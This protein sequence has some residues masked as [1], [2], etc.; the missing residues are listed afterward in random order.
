M[1]YWVL[2]WI[3]IGPWLRVL[4]RP[5][6]EG[7]EHVPATGPAIL[8]SNHV[9]FIDSVFLPLMV[10]R[11]IRF[12]AKSEYFT[13][14]GLKGWLSRLFF[15]TIGCVPVDRA[16]GRAA[17]AALDAGKQVLEEGKLWGMYPEG[18]RS[19]DGQ[20]YRGKTGVA[21]LA[22]ESG[23]PVI[24]CAMVN[25]HEIQPAGAKLPRLNKRVHMRIGAPLDF[26]R[27]AGMAGD[28]FVERS[29]TDEIMYNLME[30]SGQEYVD[31]YAAKVKKPDKPAHGEA[32]ADKPTPAHT[33][34]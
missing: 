31:V 14:K 20:L 9:A 26:S 2:K 24:P 8:A 25:F 3:L 22:L 27:Y 18:T 12:M 15:T 16:G 5:K 19:P 4:W 30:L 32:T 17:R 6:V 13:G 33:A 10:H 7:L 34:A 29:V 1:L 28:R 11:P 23:V 21:R